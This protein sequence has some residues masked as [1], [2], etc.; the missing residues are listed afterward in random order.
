MQRPIVVHCVPRN[1]SKDATHMQH[2]RVELAPWSLSS[3]TS[4]FQKKPDLM[5]DTEMSR[6][7]YVKTRR[8]VSSDV[9]QR[10]EQGHTIKLKPWSLSGMASVLFSARSMDSSVSKGFSATGAPSIA[11][12]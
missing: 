10:H 4:V 6:L 7:M 8:V 5:S 3:M 12:D 11:A 9:H 1:A 2:R